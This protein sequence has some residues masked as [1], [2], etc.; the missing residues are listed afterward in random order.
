[1]KKLLPIILLLAG[2]IVLIVVFFVV[3]GKNK[4]QEDN[5][6]KEEIALLELSLEERPVVSLTP[7]SDGHYLNLQVERIGFSP[8]SL[9]Y[10]LVYQVPG[11]VQQGVPG[12]VNLDGKSEFEAELLLG[13]ES[14]GK[15]RYDEGVEEGSLTLSFR[16]KDGQ[17]LARFSTAFHLQSNTNLLIS[18]DDEFSY[19]MDEESDEYFITMNTI[20]FPGDFSGAANKGPFGIFS[21]SSDENPGVVGQNIGQIYYWT[22]GEWEKLDEHKSSD[23]GI[24]LAE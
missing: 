14:S 18:Q 10:E 17:L 1:M 13:S 5:T 21:S 22:E 16:N 24:F 11:G 15:F 6:T 20:G 19:Q 3:R 8:F 2:V 4:E 23:T 9:D 7:T 12:S